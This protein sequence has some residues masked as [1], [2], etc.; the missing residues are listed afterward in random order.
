MKQACLLLLVLCCNTVTAQWSSN[1]SVNNAVCNFTGSQTNVQMVADNTGGYIAVWEDTRNTSTDIYAQRV[2][3]TGTLLWAADGVALCTA[4]FNQLNPKIVTDGAGGAVIAWMD[5]RNGGGAGNYD[6]YAQRVNASGVVQWSADGLPVCTA[7]GIQNNQQ[8]LADNSGAMIVWSDGR[9]GSANAD[10]YAQRLNQAGTP[11]WT[12]DGVGVCTASSLQNIPQIISDG[13]AG[14]AIICW[15]DWRN[16]GQPD[17][18]A[19]HI[20][21]GFT[22]WAFNGVVICSEPNLAQQ[23]NT[24]MVA[25]GSGGAIMC[26]QDKR[27]FG[28]NTDLYAQRVNNTGTPLWTT[29]GIAICTANGI[30]ISQ[31]MIADASGGAIITWEDRRTDRDIYAQRINASGASQW[32]ADGIAVCNTFDTQAE[33]QLVARLAGGAVFVWSDL[34]NSGQQDIYAQGIDATGT[35]LWPANGVPVANE[36]H[37]QSAPQLL[38]DGANGAII[39]WQDLRTTLDYDIYSSKLFAGGTLPL[40]MLSFNAAANNTNVTLVW[41]TENEINSSHFEVEV[42][43]DGITF[44]KIATVKANNSPVKNSYSFVHTN[45]T[46][47]I[48]FYRLKQVD[49][50][51]RFTY[52]PTI[53]VNLN[54]STQIKIYPNPASL[55][56]R[57]KN[58]DPGTVDYIQIISADG[59]ILMEQKATA[60]MQVNIK[61]IPAGICILRVVK[62][63]KTVQSFSFIK[64]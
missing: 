5:D 9:S 21:N 7:T 19:Q 8:L 64:Q 58:I 52:S 36:A 10:I 40:R 13:G 17:I 2:S 23:F 31:Q 39:A 30:Q 43:L 6:I 3:A 41:N 24:K 34:R 50:D 16:F 28:S 57:V 55:M 4:A 46:D 48:L 1:P 25:D 47:N 42:S 32:A 56:L 12:I 26:W 27:N 61:N 20:A 15:E 35:S 63:D 18:Y 38:T 33:P 51:D 22:D 62:K 11:L 37:A 45:V 44:T 53:K 29:N 59:K 49:L 14:S 60:T 54:S